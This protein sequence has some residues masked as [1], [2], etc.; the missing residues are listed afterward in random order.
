MQRRSK[1]KGT[2]NEKY[3]SL[4]SSETCCYKNFKNCVKRHQSKECDPLSKWLNS[5]RAKQLQFALQIQLL[6]YDDP[7][8]LQWKLYT[9]QFETQFSVHCHSVTHP[10][11]IQACKLTVICK[12]IHLPYSSTSKPTNHTSAVRFVFSGMALILLCA[13]QVQEISVLRMR[14]I[15]SLP[16]ENYCVLLRKSPC[17]MPI[18]AQVVGSQ[19]RVEL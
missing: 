8:L 17:E 9:R 12:A 2:A 10:L 15:Y 5:L 13:L 16:H 18:K 1:P 3:F 14:Q 11:N 4:N 19:V 7:G 6:W